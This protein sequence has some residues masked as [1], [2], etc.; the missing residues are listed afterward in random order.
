MNCEVS[1]RV[2]KETDSARDGLFTPA[3]AE[4]R[5]KY[6]GPEVQYV[7]WTSFSRKPMLM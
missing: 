7:I 4:S 6:P 2:G 1:G 5:E 3:I